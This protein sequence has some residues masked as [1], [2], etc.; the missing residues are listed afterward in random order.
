M[1]VQTQK[2]KIILHIPKDFNAQNWL[3]THNTCDIFIRPT[4][5]ESIAPNQPTDRTTGA[6][7][8]RV[9][10]EADIAQITHNDFLY[11]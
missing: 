4:F 3:I 10:T 11:K 8:S 6:F 7:I 9:N 5:L 2:K 1:I